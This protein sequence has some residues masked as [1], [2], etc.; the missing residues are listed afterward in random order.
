MQL[1][2]TSS[3]ANS[4]ANYRANV[5]NN[6]TS[7]AFSTYTVTGGLD[8]SIGVDQSDSNRFKIARGDTLGAPNDRI[9][10]DAGGMLLYNST[11]G[12]VPNFFNY[13]EEYSAIVAG[14]GAFTGNMNFN[15]VRIGTMC[16]I[17]WADP[18]VWTAAAS[19]AVIFTG[20]IPARMRPLTQ[21]MFLVRIAQSGTAAVA[22]LEIS[23][24][25][26]LTFY[27]NVTGGG[28]TSGNINNR[29]YSSCVS[30]QFGN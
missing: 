26:T 9:G 23:S 28:W 19:N 7:D 11:S 12:Y 27:N 16:H 21:K 18:G 30:Y 4:H 2:N 13:Y 10:F 22:L 8:W 5:V 1:T 25:G 3:S 6:G 20:A 24:A 14:S 15:F 17:G 29:I